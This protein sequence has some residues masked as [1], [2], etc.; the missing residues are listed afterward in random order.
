MIS[1]MQTFAFCSS[2]LEGE[3]NEAWIFFLGKSLAEWVGG[4]KSRK[5]TP[6]QGFVT[7]LNALTKPILSL[8]GR[9]IIEAHA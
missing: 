9:G 2:P 7:R 6:H 3:G 5:N 4:R 8:K 1:D